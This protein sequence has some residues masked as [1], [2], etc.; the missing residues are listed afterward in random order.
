MSEVIECGPCIH[1]GV[2]TCPGAGTVNWLWKHVGGF[3]KCAITSAN[4]EEP[5]LA[6]PEAYENP[7]IVIMTPA[8][9]DPEHVRNVVY[10]H[11]T[12]DGRILKTVKVGQFCWVPNVWQFW[13]VG[14][15]PW[16]QEVFIEV[17]NLFDVLL[18]EKHEPVTD[19]SPSAD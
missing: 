7:P 4:K 19:V 10:P 6:E 15:G 12:M 3:Y 14:T 16:S 9:Q 18:E 5:T 13:F 11:Y 8:P 17:A 1:C 2:M